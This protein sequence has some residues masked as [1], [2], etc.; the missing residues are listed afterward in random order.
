MEKLKEIRRIWN[1]NHLKMN[2]IDRLLTDKVED[3]I[4]IQ[5]QP[6]PILIKDLTGMGGD[7]V[8][9]VGNFTFDNEHK[10]FREWAM[11]ISNLMSRL[12]NME[13]MESRRKELLE[14]ANFHMLAEGKWIMEFLMM[15][16]WLKKQLC[17]LL[18]KTLLKQQAYV[19]VG[20]DRV[21]KEWNNCD[22][23]F[24]KKNVTKELL[25]QICWLIYLYNFDSQ[26]KSLRLIT[27]KMGFQ[28]LEETYIP[29]WLQNLTGLTGKF[30]LAQAGNID[31]YCGD[32]QN[33]T[34]SK[35][36]SQKSSPEEPEQ[37]PSE[38]D[39][40]FEKKDL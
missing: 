1:N 29:F 10:F 21:L 37:E 8:L 12:T 31:Y 39:K 26:K 17:K 11:I 2:T 28:Q 14:K 13:L 4:L 9:Y 32:L 16:D 24:F 6:L 7:R 38:V 40:E 5:E 22:Y 19:L 30:V 34:N 18:N 36:E 25:I 35:E 3:Y 23:D 33:S 20:N 15:D 27:E